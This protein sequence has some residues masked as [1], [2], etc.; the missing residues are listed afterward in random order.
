MVLVIT[1]YLGPYSTQ[2]ASTLALTHLYR[3]Y[4]KAIFWVHLDPHSLLQKKKVYSL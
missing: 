3:D 4:F 2:Q 1:D